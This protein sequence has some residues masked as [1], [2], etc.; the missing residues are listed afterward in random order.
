[1]HDFPARGRENHAFWMH[2]CIIMDDF[3]YFI[4][5]TVQRIRAEAIAEARLE[6]RL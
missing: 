3:G 2:F 5:F 1:M 4:N 6:E